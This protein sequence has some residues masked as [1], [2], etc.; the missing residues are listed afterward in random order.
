LAEIERLSPAKLITETTSSSTVMAFLGYVSGPAIFSLLVS[1][2]GG[3]RL[4][5]LV[6]AA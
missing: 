3:Y 5:F 1:W 4:S 6:I 2:S